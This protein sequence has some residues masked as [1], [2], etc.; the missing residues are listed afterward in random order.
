M[1]GSVEIAGKRI[2]GVNANVLALPAKYIL[3]EKEGNFVLVGKGRASEKTAW[4]SPPSAK[5]G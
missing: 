4:S 1:T 2:A 3:R 5:S